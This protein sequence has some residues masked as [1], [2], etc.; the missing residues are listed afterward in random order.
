MEQR[1]DGKVD[2]MGAEDEID[3]PYIGYYSRFRPG[4]IQKSQEEQ[5]EDWRKTMIT[6]KPVEDGSQANFAVLPTNAPAQVP[7]VTENAVVE[8]DTTT[9]TITIPELP[10][11]FFCRRYTIFIIN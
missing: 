4:S 2:C 11:Q 1:C 5:S 9:F 6:S 3:C 8:V 7:P 10:P